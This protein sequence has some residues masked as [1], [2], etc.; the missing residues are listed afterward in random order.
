MT[1]NAAPT[2]GPIQPSRRRVIVNETRAMYGKSVAPWAGLAAM[3]VAGACVQSA[4]V[5]AG[6][7]AAA[8]PIATCGT[9]LAAKA[10]MRARAV[11]LKRIERGQRDGKQV[12]RIVRNARRATGVVAAATTWLAVIAVTDPST[13]FGRAAWVAGIAGWAVTSYPWWRHV[14]RTGARTRPAAPQARTVVTERDPLAAYA[15]DT[16]AQRIGHPMGPLAGT[17]LTNFR[18][19]PACEAGSPGRVR[20]PNWT[21]QVEA[22]E[23]GTINM[24]EQRPLLLGRI[25]TAYGCS[26]GDVAFFTDKH[27]L[28]RAEVRVQPDNLLA[29]T[30]LWRGLEGTDWGRGRS[31]VGRYDD[32]K[33]MLYQWHKEN[34][35]AVHDLIS[36]CTGSGKSELVAQ[37]LLISQHSRG[38][39]LDWVGDPQGG[40]SYGQLKDLVDWFAPN[41]TEIKLMLLAAKIEMIRRNHAL[42][43]AHVKT[44]TPTLDMPLLVV[45]LDEAQSY[46]DDPDILQLITDLAGMGRKS[47][48]KMRLLTQVP[49]AGNLGGSV[50]IK[51]Q[52]RVQAFIGRAATEVAG[53]LA[54]DPDS[55]FDP[56]ELPDTWGPATCDPEGTTAGLMGVQGINGRDVFGRVD[57][58]GND[59]S[60]WLQGELSPG[61]FSADA[62]AAPG[63]SQ[64]WGERHERTRLAIEQ[65]LSLTTML[66]G[67]RALE[68]ITGASVSGAGAGAL[69]LPGGPSQA[70]MTARDVVLA[71]AR[72]VVD[73]DGTVTK[74]AIIAQ[75]PDLRSSTRDRAITD[76]MQAG[77]LDRVKSGVYR[78][79]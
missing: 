1:V 37:L 8:V 65:G 67:G 3:T 28:S 32:G 51:E 47:G 46:L 75:T 38:L 2:M 69:A 18:R 15:I 34:F 48:I 66:P 71:A 31:V 76:L 9:Y 55:V 40:Q 22:I 17:R 6:A 20:Q 79:C 26:Y 4:S 60:V 12:V 77:K 33:P 10:I 58:T 53:R 21:A 39:V 52:V 63:Q 44:W 7:V 29:E 27:N 45:T 54:V 13:T 42:A 5:G 73:N 78:L 36:G 72:Q 64:L 14:E 61:V 62:Q 11:K 16:W 41:P 68:L 56:R 50:Y 24:R 25:A 57:Y 35:G 23:A 30:R 49:S 74:Q 70:E 19:L 43:A 59:M